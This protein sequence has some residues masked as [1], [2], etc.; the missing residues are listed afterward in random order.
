MDL[1]F[2]IAFPTTD[3][4][5]HAQLF[6]E[7]RDLCDLPPSI[8]AVRMLVHHPLFL[9]MGDGFRCGAVCI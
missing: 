6:K 2:S 1:R 7:C 5:A 4:F 3:D 9:H 8:F